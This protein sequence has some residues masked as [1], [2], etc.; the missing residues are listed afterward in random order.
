MNDT[1]EA[2]S[3]ALRIRSARHLQRADAVGEHERRENVERRLLCHTQQGG[4]E[5]LARLLPDHLDDGRPLDLPRREK[6]PKDRRLE[7]A[8]PDPEPDADQ[9]NAEEERYAPAPGGEVGARSRRCTARITRFDRNRPD[10]TPNCGH[11][12]TSPRLPWSRAHSME[13]RTRATPFTADAD[14]LQHPQYR[15]DDCAPDADRRVARDEG[16]EECGDA[17][18]HQRGDEGRLAADAV[19]IMAEDR[20]ADRP[21]DEA[22]EVG[23]ERCER[24]GQ[25]IFVGEEELR[26]DQPGGGAV[27]EE[28]VPFDRRADSGGD[29][30]LAQFGAVLCI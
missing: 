22:D 8:E 21:T 9:D 28:V 17:H 18:H 2:T 1:H 15:Q 25:R 24:A 27:D 11:A 10:G 19:A 13:I 12:A 3:T 7:D 26:E 30:R 20:G 6:L 5:D 14:A 4:Q 23:A 16:D 29:H